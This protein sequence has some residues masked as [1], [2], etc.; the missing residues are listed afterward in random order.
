[1]AGHLDSNVFFEIKLVDTLKGQ[2][3]KA[4]ICV[5]NYKTPQLIK[6]CLRSIRKFTHTPHKV[7]VVDNDSQDESLEYLRTVKWIE[8][9]ERGFGDEKILGSDAEGS[10][11]D[12]GLNRCDSEFYVTMHSDTIIKKDNWLSEL[13][14]YFKNNREIACVGSGKIESQSLWRTVLKKATDFKALQRRLFWPSELR[15]QYLYH[16]RTICCLYRT[17]ILRKEKLTFLMG[18][19]RHL[20]AGQGLYLE[21]V[22]RQY[23]TV[24]LPCSVMGEY[25]IHLNHATMVLNPQEFSC[26]RRT[27]EKYKSKVAKVMSSDLIANLL[28]DNSLDA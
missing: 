20:T 10:G 2:V 19:E 23:L 1:V 5:V 17:E 24:E 21:L 14:V 6:L 11:L 18:K 9:V 15:E 3:A 13:L 25:V 22:K 8:L 26:K 28:A 7:I 4:T 27:V 16:N 12:I